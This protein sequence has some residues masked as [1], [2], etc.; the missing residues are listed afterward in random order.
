MKCKCAETS[1]VSI[2]GVDWLRCPAC[3]TWH[4][5]AVRASLL[6]GA[7]MGDGKLS[8]RQRQEVAYADHGMDHADGNFSP[9]KWGNR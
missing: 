3:Q 4:G 7:P 9:G 2:N 6:D 1:I 8:L 5:K